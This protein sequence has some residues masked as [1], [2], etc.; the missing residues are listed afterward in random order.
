[1]AVNVACEVDVESMPNGFAQH[2]TVS[3][4]VLKQRGSKYVDMS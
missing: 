1:M 3:L 4:D 2:H